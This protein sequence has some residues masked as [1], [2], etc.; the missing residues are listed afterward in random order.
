M[1]I[2]CFFVF[3]I[4][5]FVCVFM[6]VCVCWFVVFD[7]GKLCVYYF[8]YCSYGDFVLVWSM[9]LCVM[10]KCIWLVVGLDYWFSSVVWCYVI[11]WVFWGVLVDC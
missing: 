4:C 8:N 6:G 11:N 3:V 7:F 10:C 1:L 9:L 5:I 2:D